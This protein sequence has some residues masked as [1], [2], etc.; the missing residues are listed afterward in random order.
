MLK[1]CLVVDDSHVVR[2]V[3]RRMLEGLNFCVDEAANGK[4]A[5]EA[6]LKRMP[7]AVLLDWNMPVMTGIEF[8]RELRVAPGGKEPVVVFCTTHFDLDHIEQ[9]L[10]AGATEY[11]IKPFDGEILHEKLSQLGLV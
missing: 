3:A 11:I 10:G 5:L 8:L 2:T 6:C 7:D 1:S 9:A 4:L